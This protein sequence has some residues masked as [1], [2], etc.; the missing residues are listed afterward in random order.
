MDSE[1]L[2]ALVKDAQAKF[3]AL[4]SEQQA[5][6]R[7]EQRRS[8]VRGQCPSRRDYAEWC[9]DVDKLLPPRRPAEYPHG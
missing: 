2:I 8:F 7:Y 9:K 1:V 3:N 6:H 4:T 5:D